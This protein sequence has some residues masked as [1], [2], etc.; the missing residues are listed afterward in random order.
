MQALERLKFFVTGVLMICTDCF[1]HYL[2]DY[3]KGFLKTKLSFSVKWPL[4]L[5]NF[6]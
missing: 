4:F 1:F 5:P 3:I 2:M 6:K